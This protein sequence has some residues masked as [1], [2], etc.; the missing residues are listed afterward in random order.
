ECGAG[1]LVLDEPTSNLDVRMEAELYDRF[2]DLTA[3][4]TTIVVSHRFSTVRRA[5]RIVVLDG[6]RIVEA[7]THDELMARAGRYARMFE[8]QAR[9]YADSDDAADVRPAPAPAPEP[10]GTRKA[11][12]TKKPAA[13]K[14]AAAT[15]KT[16]ATKK[17][18]PAPEPVVVQPV[19]E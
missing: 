13:R 3:G 11:A 10:A 1:I 8:L 19:D 14:P 18:P 12:A 17:A 6:G 16:V 7:G 15:K 9:Y 2:L 4:L 5:D